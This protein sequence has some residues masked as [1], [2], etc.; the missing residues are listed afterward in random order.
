MD[1]YCSVQIFCTGV[2]VWSH[3]YAQVCNY[4]RMHNHKRFKVGMHTYPPPPTI[5]WMTKKYPAI[6][7]NPATQNFAYRKKRETKNP[8]SRPACIVNTKK[9]APPRKTLILY[10]PSSPPIIKSMCMSL[11]SVH[12]FSQIPQETLQS[13]R[14]HCKVRISCITRVPN[15][16][17]HKD[18]YENMS[19]FCFLS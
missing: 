2:E 19:P 7:H 15:S 1:P 17:I 3:Y 11:T 13:R 10:R 8:N 14:G 18:I 12:R 9:A 4:K 5:K 6:I 16:N